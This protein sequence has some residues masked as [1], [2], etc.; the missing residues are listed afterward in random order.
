MQKFRFA[1]LTLTWLLVAGAATIR[2][3]DPIAVYARVDRVVLLP[4]AEAPETIQ[5]FGVFSL[6]TPNDRNAYEPPARGYLYF[7]MAFSAAVESLNLLEKR[8]HRR[9]RERSGSP[10]A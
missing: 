5:I 6:A 1:A 2:A 9:L 4:S 7:A 8:L 10:S 3:S